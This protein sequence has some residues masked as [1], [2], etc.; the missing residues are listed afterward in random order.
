MTEIDPLALPAL[1]AHEL[2]HI[3]H[4]DPMA[5]AIRQN[6]YLGMWA[7]I[8][9]GTGKSLELKFSGL[10]ERRA[11][12]EAMAMLRRA[13]IP[14]RPAAMM[15]EEMRRS[16]AQNGFFG[17]DQRDFH[18]G[19]DDRAQR[20]ALAAANDPSRLVPILSE[21]ETDNLYNFCWAGPLSPAQRQA[22]SSTLAPG[23]GG[24]SSP[25]NAG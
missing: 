15:F 11:D 8:I 23:H 1:L 19:I 4:A 9:E 14:L 21:I 13:G 17:Y 5:A 10:E 18:F 22:P 16:K 2:S 24:V 25:P 6:G 20:W 7:S 12:L 3:R